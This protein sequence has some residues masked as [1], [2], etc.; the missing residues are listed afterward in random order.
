MPSMTSAFTGRA[1]SGCGGNGES[2]AAE[3]LRA[4]RGGRMHPTLFEQKNQVDSLSSPAYNLRVMKLIKLIAG[5]AMTAALFIAPVVK[6]DGTST[7]SVAVK[8]IPYPLTVCPVSDEKLGGDMGAPYVFVYKG[9]EIKFCC[10][11]CKKDFLKDPDK[12]LKKIKTE[13]AK[14][15][16]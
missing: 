12:Y 1:S 3:L 7:N 14:L 8:P 4:V 16:K 13:A 2:N 11:S 6:A 15:K 5:V 9:Q 10:S